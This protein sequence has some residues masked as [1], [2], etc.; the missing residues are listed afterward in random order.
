MTGIPEE[1]KQQYC[2]IEGNL[3]VEQPKDIFDRMQMNII[4][5]LISIKGEELRRVT[6]IGED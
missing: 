3:R 2:V 4:P 5:E 6:L 1:M